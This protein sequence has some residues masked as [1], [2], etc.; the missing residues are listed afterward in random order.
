MHTHACASTHIHIHIHIYTYTR[1]Y[2]HMHTYTHIYTHTHTHV[3]VRLCRISWAQYQGY[4][5]K[6]Q[7]YL[8][9]AGK[10]VVMSPTIANAL[11]Y[12]IHT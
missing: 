11:V 8:L 7:C 9:V 2:A 10:S 4:I 3:R 5:G 6:T 1:T 12:F